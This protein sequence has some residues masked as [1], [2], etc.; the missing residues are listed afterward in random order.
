MFD[1]D[2]LIQRK[3]YSDKQVLG[4]LT[5]YADR[6]KPIYDCKTLELADKDNQRRISCIPLGVYKVVSRKSAK[7]GNHYHILDVTNR[8]FIL[9]HHGNYHTDILGCVLVGK[10]H[11]DINKDGY[12]DV[13]SS[14]QVM[15]ELNELLPKE[16][17]LKIT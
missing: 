8:D 7:Y 9:I 14:K 10:T 13:T 15:K 1:F 16:F 2:V 17:V 11:A 5:I 4:E 6:V 3:E 12:A